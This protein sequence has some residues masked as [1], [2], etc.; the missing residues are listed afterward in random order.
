MADKP[1][2]IDIRENLKPEQISSTEVVPPGSIE[3]FDVEKWKI[4]A[5]ITIS[6]AALLL[7]FVALII[8]VYIDDSELKTWAT[9]LISLVVG[10]ALGFA[11]SNTTQV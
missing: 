6:G 2:T 3:P 11:F 8:A 10:A 7:G 9:G 5:A 1:E 4:L